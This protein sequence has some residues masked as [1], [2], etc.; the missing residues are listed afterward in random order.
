MRRVVEVYRDIHPWDLH[1]GHW[2]IGSDLFEAMR[3]DAAR[4]ADRDLPP[5]PNTATIMG[6][7]V[8]IGPNGSG[9]RFEV[10]E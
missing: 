10:G 2:V 1:R 7:R 8:E 6:Q 3:E 4:L 5:L 9:I